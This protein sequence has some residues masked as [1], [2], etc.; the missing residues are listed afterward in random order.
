MNIYLL[1]QEINFDYNTYDSCIVCAE[2]EDEARNIHPDENYGWESVIKSWVQENEKDK[3]TVEL[4]GKANKNIKK[5]VILA[6]F[7][8]G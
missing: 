6:S 1:S 4:I 7:N 3:I 8:A 5:G 2:N